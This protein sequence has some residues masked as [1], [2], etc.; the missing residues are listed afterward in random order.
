[1]RRPWPTRGCCAMGRKKV[2]EKIINNIDSNPNGT[3]F[4][5]RRQ[6]IAYADDVLILGRL[7][8]VIESVATQI[9]KQH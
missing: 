7:V 6:Y 9:Q 4:N 8:R 5:R 3:V 2:L 1:M